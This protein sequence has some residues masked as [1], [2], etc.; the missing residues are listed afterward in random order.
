MFLCRHEVLGIYSFFVRWRWACSLL[1]RSSAVVS[2]PRRIFVGW[3]GS[4]SSFVERSFPLFCF[5][6]LGISL[7]FFFVHVRIESGAKELVFTFWCIHLARLFEQIHPTLILDNFC[8]MQ[9]VCVFVC[10]SSKEQKQSALH[11]MSA[12]NKCTDNIRELLDV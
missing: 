9:R 10:A 2:C 11:S 7:A 3:K 6:G 4:L 5:Y 12:S 1:H 8:S